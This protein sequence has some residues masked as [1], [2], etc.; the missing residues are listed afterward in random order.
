MEK[1]E[2]YSTFNKKRNNNKCEHM[3]WMFAVGGPDNSMP[4][5]IADEEHIS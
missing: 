2:Y 4:T 3:K 1:N 5:H